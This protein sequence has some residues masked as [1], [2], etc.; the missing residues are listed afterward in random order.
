MWLT[1]KRGDGDLECSQGK[2]DLKKSGT[3]GAHCLM[4]DSVYGTFLIYNILQ[5]VARERQDFERGKRECRRH[6]SS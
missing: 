1:R 3:K 6:D 4:M 2:G 5:V